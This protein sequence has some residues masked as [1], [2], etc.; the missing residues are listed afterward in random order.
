MSIASLAKRVGIAS[1]VAASAAA[2]A[3]T[4]VL[5]R[6]DR[7]PP[8]PGWTPPRWPDGDR[9]I[10]TTDD[11]A[12]LVVE[13]TG[14]TGAPTVMLVH[15]LTGDHE[16]LGHIASA[17]IDRGCR[18]VG[19]NQRGHGGSTVGTDGFGPARQGADLGRVLTALDLHD[20]TL[21]GHSMGGVAAMAL[22]TLR[23][24]TGARRVSGL[25]LVATLADSSRPDRDTGLKFQGT[26]L[27][28]RLRSNPRHSVAL[29]RWVFGPTPSRFE[30]DAAI[31]VARRC[32]DETGAGA[33]AGML[34]YDIRPLL[35][36]ITQPTIVICGTRDLLTRHS[37]NEA[38]ARAIP[39][40]EF[41]SIDGCGHM[42]IWE[43]PDSIVDAVTSLVGRVALVDA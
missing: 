30:L 5:R 34:D 33:A 37:E 9:Q 7:T 39:D 11:G 21:V 40:A 19:V 20:V 17:L 3:E 23:P 43:D 35:G 6:I 29:A 10:V 12:D 28:D 1:A 2:L 13:S 16:S 32:P 14:P 26:S 24:E 22:L 25:V 42:V 36:N 41:R 18:V 15:G 38:I 8:R 31:D 27:Y 4:A